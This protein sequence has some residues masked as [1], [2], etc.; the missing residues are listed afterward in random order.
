MFS[1]LAEFVWL[2]FRR[3]QAGFYKVFRGVGRGVFACVGR[4]LVCR[5]PGLGCRIWLSVALSDP[6]FDQRTPANMQTNELD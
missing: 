6:K 3:L 5:I 2:G 1:R 4:A